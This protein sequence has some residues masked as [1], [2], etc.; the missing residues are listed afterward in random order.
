M[1]FTSGIRAQMQCCANTVTKA[2]LPRASLDISAQHGIKR[3]FFCVKE[4]KPSSSC[5]I[6]LLQHCTLACLVSQR[7]SELAVCPGQ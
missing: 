7:C 6:P 1:L 4:E 5:F 3:L 2:S